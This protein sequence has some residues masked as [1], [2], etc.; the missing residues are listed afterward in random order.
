MRAVLL[1]KLAAAL[2]S[3]S[4]LVT[5]AYVGGLGLLALG[6]A[7][8]YLPAGLIVAGLTSAAT[9]VLYARNSL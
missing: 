1:A 3:E 2:R 8:I 9:S 6:V 5:A 7:L 4:V